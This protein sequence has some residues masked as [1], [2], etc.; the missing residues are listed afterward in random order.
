MAKLMTFVMTATVM[1]MLLTL[2]G[3]NT[4]AGYVLGQLG[5]LDNPSGF[6]GTTLYVAIVAALT[7]LLA[8]SAIRIGFFGVNA[9]DTFVSA[10]LAITLGAFIAD[11]V[12]VI[13]TTSANCPAS[14]SCG[15]VTYVVT[16]IMGPIIIGYAISLFDWARGND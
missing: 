5:M 7:L 16:L 15:W 12:S 13:T 9:P 1:M 11:F 6:E 8:S 10:S 4:T 3:V 14:S 2:V